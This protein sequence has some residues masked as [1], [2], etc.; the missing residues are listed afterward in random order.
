MDSQFKPTSLVSGDPVIEKAKKWTF[1]SA[2]KLFLYFGFCFLAATQI[3][4]NIWD[5]ELKRFTIILGV[6]GIWR[7]SWW[8]VH[9]VRSE[10]YQHKVFPKL[11]QK[12]NVI[13]HKGW[14]PSHV[15]FMMTTYLERRDTTERVIQSIC[16][17][18]RSSGMKATLWLGSGDSYDEKIISNYLRQYAQDLDLEFIMVRQNQP[19]KRLAIGLVL[20]A[21]SRRGIHPDDMIVFMDGDAILAPDILEKCLPLFAGDPKLQAV[22]TDEDVLCFGPKWMQTWLTMRFAQRRIAM[23]SHSLSQKVLT[24]TG[25]MSVFRANHL[26]RH[27]FIR[28]L[29]SDHLEHWLWGK[30]RFLSGDDKSTWYYML[31]QDAKMLYVPDALV[32]TVEE[33]EGSGIERMTQNFRRWSG[34][35]LR[36]GARA[37]K[38][39]PR[40]VGFFIWWCV[41]DQRIAMWTMLV[42]PIVAFNVSLLI[43]PTYILSYFLW[44]AISRMALSLFLYRYCEQV[45]MWFPWILYF[46]QLLN[47]SVKVYCIFRLSKQRWT[48]RG[49]Q[50][51]GFNESWTEQLR[52]W[53]ATYVTTVWVFALIFGV[54]L[55]T[56]V[57]MPPSWQSVTAF[58]AS[59]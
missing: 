40:K 39:G 18:V 4:N 43:E 50:S 54:A 46:N 47:A 55:Y 42:S 49:D 57:L 26:T 33:V 52:N 34:N 17:E 53:M 32:Y 22:T 44:I 24:L 29:E 28:I 58:L 1:L 13:W 9:V 6:L 23:Q 59:S 10:L 20:R 25:R 56:S 14:R 5:D 30:F 35:M 48:N 16:R 8:S 11:R 37:L 36:N 31:K 38:L 3:P 21:M 51:S 15:H 12:A 41:L 7:Y 45:Y 2:Y 27:E 19:G